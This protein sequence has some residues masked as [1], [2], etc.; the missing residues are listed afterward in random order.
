MD[1][2]PTN[3]FTEGNYWTSPEKADMVLNMAYNQ[4][5][6]S[7]YFFK[8][9]ALSDNIYEGRGSSAEKPYRPVRLMLQMHVLLMNGEIVMKG[10]KHAMYF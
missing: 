9:E 6:N 7:D 8:T 3:K 5:Y 1:L 4:M 2:V 10:S